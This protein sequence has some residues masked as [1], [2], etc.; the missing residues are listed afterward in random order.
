MPVIAP[1]VF[2]EFLISW[3][4]LLIQKA[5][6]QNNTTNVRCEGNGAKLNRV[7]VFASLV[8]LSK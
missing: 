2:M 8:F 5:S 3:E 7:F 6:F 1:Q 4:A